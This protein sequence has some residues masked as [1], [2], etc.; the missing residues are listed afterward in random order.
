MHEREDPSA[1]SDQDGARERALILAL[2]RGE[3]NDERLQILVAGIDIELLIQQLTGLK[4]L[5]LLGQRL[6]ERAPGMLGASFAEAVERVVSAGRRDSLDQ[7]MATWRLLRL[8]ERRGVVALPLKGPFFAERLL[9]D[10]GLRLSKDIDLLVSIRDIKAATAVLE[11]IGYVRPRVSDALPKLHH[12]FQLEGGPDVEL[13]WRVHWYETEFAEEMLGRS[14]LDGD[15]RRPAPADELVMLLL[16]HARD[17]LQGLRAPLDVGAWW[18]LYHGRVEG[19]D[20]HAI[21]GRHPALGPP[22][23]ASATAIQRL[24]GV[25]ITA[26]LPPGR[27]ARRTQLAVR[28][29]GWSATPLDPDVDTTAKVVD[30]LL[31]P[32]GGFREFVGR[33][34]FPPLLGSRATR[35]L[36]QVIYAAGFARRTTRVVK[37]L[38][39]TR[40]ST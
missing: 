27:F 29:A 4:L 39:S 3:T 23:A 35:P 14:V 17:G 10:P 19:P 1:D 15:A 34:V 37:R 38:R 31:T 22:V 13:H 24:L 30:A 20:I 32:R 26:L 6:L 21:L 36:R 28:L 33:A 40:H 11:G 9:G 25:P 18:S 5:G 8:L 12:I 16:I 2:A 7:L